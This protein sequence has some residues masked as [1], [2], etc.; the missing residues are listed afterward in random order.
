MGLTSTI[1]VLRVLTSAPGRGCTGRRFRPTALALF[2]RASVLIFSLATTRRKK[3]RRELD[4]LTC[5]R[6]TVMRFARMRLP[7]VLFTMIPKARFVTLNTRP[8][9]P[10]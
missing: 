6:R 4:C 9:R 5:S 8:V 7:I 10:W 1:S 3:S 2:L